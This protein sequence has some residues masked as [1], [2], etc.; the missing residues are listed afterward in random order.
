MPDWGRIAADIGVETGMHIQPDSIRPVS[1]G[2]INAA[3]R[4]VCDA[5]QLFLK[6]N[7][8]T[9]IDM[10]EAERDGLTALSAAGAL[11]VPRPLATGVTARQAWFA[12]EWIEPGRSR[13]STGARLGEGLARQHG[14][15]AEQFGWHRDNTIGTTP[16]INAWHDDW[17]AFF[18]ER[19]IRYQLNL[20]VQGGHPGRLMESGETLLDRVGMFFTD[21]QPQPSLLHGDLWGGNWAADREGDPFVFDPAVYYGDREADLAMTELFGGFDA[22][23]QA[24][25]RSAWPLDPGY[26]TR[27]QLYNLYHVLN[28]LNLFGTSYLAQAEAMIGRLISATAG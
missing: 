4:V 25:Y 5:G 16:Q 9:A 28:H 18:A 17:P 13:A 19:R 22:T 10:F 11:R 24:A 14:H 12:M 1:G 8:A 3:W 20:A 21:Y 26:E 15:L 27:R 23:F 6:T 7:D 2:C